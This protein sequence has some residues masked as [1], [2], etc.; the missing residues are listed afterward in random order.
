MSGPAALLIDFGSTYTKLRAVDLKNRTLLGSGQ[1]PSTVTSDITIGMRTALGDLE[2]QLGRL[3]DFRYR[4]AS[5]SAAGGLKMVTVGLVRE[6]TAEAARFA[7]LGA[8]ARLVDT[9]AYQLSKRDMARITGHDP[10]IILLA[11]GTDGGNSEVIVNNAQTLAASGL[12]C[13]II[14][15][16]NRSAADDAEEILKHAGKDVRVTGNVM[17]ALGTLEIE[18]ARAAIRDVFI[19]RIV[20]AKGLDRAHDFFDALAMPTPVAVLEAARLLSDGPHGRGGLGPLLVVDIGGATTDVYSV[21]SG[22][23]TEGRILQHGLPEPFAK[24][25]VEGDLGMRHNAGEIIEAA[26]GRDAVAAL[27]GATPAEV[28]VLLERIAADVE[29]LPEGEG[30]RAF[31]AA[32]AQC[33]IRIAVTRHAGTVEIVHT[34]SGPVA[35]QRG[36]DLSP[37]ATVIGTGGALVYGRNASS[38]LSGCRFSEDEPGSLRPRDPALLVDNNYLLYAAGLLAEVEPEAAFDFARASL[39]PVSEQSVKGGEN[40]LRVTSG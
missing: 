2:E 6:L 35:A 30:E 18:P 34:V 20:H 17:P 19:A 37:V 15:A 21:A 40:E 4:L 10:D 1:G 13:P 26:G 22:E 29:R 14:V 11:G 23:P 39:E 36:K 27:A 38:I 9:F 28:D 3:P 12:T 31:D 25:T 32:L 16:G 7:A 33:A 5:S 24:R 8:G